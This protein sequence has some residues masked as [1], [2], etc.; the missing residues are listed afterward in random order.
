[1]T[2]GPEF[3]YGGIRVH[4]VPFPDTNKAKETY[5]AGILD[6]QTKMRALSRHRTTTLKHISIW[7]AAAEAA[8]LQDTH[9]LAALLYHFQDP[10]S[11]DP[12]AHTL[13]FWNHSST[14]LL[15]DTAI[16]ALIPARYLQHPAA[17]QTVDNAAWANVTTKPTNAAPATTTFNPQLLTDFLIRPPSP[18]PDHQPEHTG[19]HDASENSPTD[20][21]H[22]PPPQPKRTRTEPAFHSLTTQELYN[23]ATDTQYFVRNFYPITHTQRDYPGFEA[24]RA[25][26]LANDDLL[27]YYPQF[28]NLLIDTIDRQDTPTSLGCRFS[29]F[30]Q[31]Q[32]P[33][34]PK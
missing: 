9:R 4:P 5:V 14:A 20:D 32:R 23:P 1:M 16:R 2:R 13:L 11:P 17:L 10:H 33:P 26:I 6:A 29:T 30:L 15:T 31:D 12:T 22:G 24:I 18:A 28:I 34:P 3:R 25:N 27:H 7:D 21:D 8:L 19:Y